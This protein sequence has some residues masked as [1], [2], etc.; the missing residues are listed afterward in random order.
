M[1]YSQE[2]VDEV[3]R[4]N[5]I[6]DVISSHVHLQKRGANYQGLCPFHNEKTPS[7][8]VSPSRQIF[9]CFGC[10]VGGN[11]I[12]FLM[13]YDNIGFQEALQQLADRAGVKL[14]ARPAVYGHPRDAAFFGD[15]RKLSRVQ[16]LLIPSQT[17]L[18]CHRQA[19]PR[20]KHHSTT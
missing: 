19:I 2:V 5:D 15:M 9:K 14:P 16:M 18:Q 17:D 7:F 1:Y 10:G 8:N 20:P 11:A 12:T 13:K 4:G 3:L 6:V